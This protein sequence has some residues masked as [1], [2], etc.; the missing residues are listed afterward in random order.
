MISPN[1]KLF[2]L[3]ENQQRYLELF[4]EAN[5][6]D[7]ELT[8]DPKLASIV[9][10]SPPL[11]AEMLEQFTALDWMQSVYAGVDALM[12]PTLR[13]DYQLTNVK[14][15]F[16]QQISEYVLGYTISYYRHFNTYQQQQHQ[17]KWQPHPYTTL[18][19]KTLTILGTGAIG[20]H[21]ARTAKALGL[22]VNGIN[23]TGIPAK[24]DAFDSTFHIDELSAVLASSNII[25]STL[26][27]TPSTHKL[28]NQHTLSHCNEALLFNVGRGEVVDGEG[29]LQALES[30]CVSHAFLDVF[31]NEPLI[32]EHPFWSHPE[33]TLTPHIAA[34]S[35][36]EQVFEIFT[37]NYLNWRD[38]FRLKNLIDFDK[39]Y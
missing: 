34:N 18:D 3:S 24:E 32:Q 15:I 35:F 13:Q 8:E 28:L 16:G 37:D 31:D 4:S 17:R 23:S 10:A 20:S 14:G 22:K 26:P 36:P 38:G 12:L 25:V 2:I 9:L 27:N 6:P 33:V 39:G 19:N 30:R 5:L 1:N 11:I 21:L 29:L 7:L